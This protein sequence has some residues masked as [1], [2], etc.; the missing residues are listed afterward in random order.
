MGRQVVYPALAKIP[1]AETNDKIGERGADNC[2]GFVTT[3]LAVSGM[4]MFE[5][6]LQ[7]HDS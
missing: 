3:S 5:L 6:L 7:R 4:F 2:W 1:K